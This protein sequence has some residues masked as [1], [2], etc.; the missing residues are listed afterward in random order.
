MKQIHYLVSVVP[1]RLFSR[2]SSFVICHS[3][4]VIR[5]SSFVI[6]H[7]SLRKVGA[8]ASYI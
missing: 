8:G 6:R 3:S 5:H 4:F 1:H 7:S 2:Y